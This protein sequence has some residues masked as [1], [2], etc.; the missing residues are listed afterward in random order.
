M[1]TAISASL[2]EAGRAGREQ[3]T[4]ADL[5]IAIAKRADY[6][7]AHVFEHAG[8]PPA[9]L[10]EALQNNGSGT[11]PPLHARPWA[12]QLSA[13]AMH[14]LDVAAD[15]A[16]RRGQ[17][18]VGTEHVALALARLDHMPAGRTLRDLGFT[19]GRA[20]LGLDDW[21]R[22]GLA[23]RR[24]EV[25]ATARLRPRSP[26][27]TALLR[28]LATAL[29][30]PAMAWHVLVG[31]SLGHPRYVTNPYPMYR[32]LRDRRPVRKDPLVPVWVVSRYADVLS[33]MRD[34]RFKKDPFAPQRLPK[35]VRE[36]LGVPKAEAVRSSR[37]SISMLFLDPPEHTRV[38]GL[39]ARAFTPRSLEALRPRVQQITDKWL[40]RAEKKQ[41]GRID[42]IA[43]LAY[44]LPVTVIAEMLGFPP[45]DY[46]KIKKW[47]D[48]LAGAL[49]LNPSTEQQER[50]GV[51]REELR[52][53]FDR[54]RDEL[55]KKPADNLISRL[56]AVSEEAGR[57]EGRGLS[58]D[59]L[60][61]NSVLLL[62]AGH[63]TTTNLIG[64]G[65][66]ALLRH[67]DQLELL[68]K[69]PGLT[70]AAVEELLRYDSPV[71]WTSR[72]AGE[73]MTLGGQSIQRGDILLAS[74]GSANRDD[75][76]F[77]DP[78]RLDVRR[79]DSKHLAFGSGPHFCLGA[80]LAR[81]E[82]ET[83]IRTL[84]RRFPGLRLERQK[85]QWH[86][87]LTFRGVKSLKLALR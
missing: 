5:L 32:W 12:E 84:V 85:L 38:R 82:G 74:I 62:A 47:S 29:R 26:A 37:E 63:E 44:P 49:G 80:A 7:G 46:E 79:P 56:L 1:R 71:Q 34:P 78:D 50:S 64:N 9:R 15:E 36:Q 27:A 59:E 21:L 76:Q 10:V 4:A 8:L 13:E 51:A 45:E 2:E 28:P 52:A 6:V 23:R 33:V 42:L 67:P 24:D 69:D 53:Y 22:N 11:G 14:V 41:G 77:P 83:A 55:R 75:R 73:D 19:Y 16:R 17:E 35:L 48:A 66:L 25:F 3:V 40:D 43:D 18:Y 61:A 72:V 39:F 70:G 20:R 86:K 57:Q 31:R 60:F 65:V 58:P 30:A 87:G 54:I 81:I 68:R